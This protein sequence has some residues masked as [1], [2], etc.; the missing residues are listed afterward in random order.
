MMDQPTPSVDE[1]L[2]Q[3]TITQYGRT[4]GEA[5]KFLRLNPHHVYIAVRVGREDHKWLPVSAR[6][7]RRMI[8]APTI[9]RTDLLP[10]EFCH[11][12]SHLWIGSW[13]A[14]SRAAGDDQ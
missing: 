5:V 9:G 6:A 3:A 13:K 8:T 10:S 4:V 7:A 2:R 12:T 14:I 11:T 1:Q